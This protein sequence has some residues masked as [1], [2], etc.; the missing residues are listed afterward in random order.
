M[1]MVLHH[2]SIVGTNAL[3]SYR[4]GPSPTQVYEIKTIVN[5]EEGL[6]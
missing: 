3:G 6:K 4:V 5:Q 2:V 1:Q